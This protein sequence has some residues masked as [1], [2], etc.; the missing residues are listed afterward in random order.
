[1]NATWKVKKETELPSIHRDFV[2]LLRY[3]L[4]NGKILEKQSILFAWHLTIILLYRTKLR[5]NNEQNSFKQTSLWGI[6]WARV[7]G[8]NF[9]K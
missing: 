1:M 7:I 2:Q 3:A 4:E 5:Q 9:S 6:I 8:S